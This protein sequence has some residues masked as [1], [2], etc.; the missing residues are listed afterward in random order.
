MSLKIYLLSDKH[1]TTERFFCD[2]NLDL[3][4]SQYI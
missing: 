2:F 4:S 3:L 1:K